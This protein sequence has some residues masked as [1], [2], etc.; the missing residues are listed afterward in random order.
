MA[1]IGGYTDVIKITIDYSDFYE[2]SSHL[3]HLLHHSPPQV[4][5]EKS[6]YQPPPDLWCDGRT[7]DDLI[8]KI[9]QEFSYTSELILS[10]LNFANKEMDIIITRDE[11]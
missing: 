1:T 5:H 11:W 4:S 6:F 2:V 10:W 8:P 9:P 7:M 3:H